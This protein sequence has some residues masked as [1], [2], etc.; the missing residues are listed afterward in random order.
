MNLK[1]IRVGGCEL[2]TFE[3]R[4]NQW[5][6]GPQVAQM[7][8]IDASSLKK[9]AA[10]NEIKT[11]IATEEEVTYLLN[12]LPNGQNTSA[13]NLLSFNETFR[14][15]ES[16][17][18]YTKSDRKKKEEEFECIYRNCR[19]ISTTKLAFYRH[20]LKHDK[21]FT[22]QTS[23][24]IKKKTQRS[25][26]TEDT[27]ITLE[28][29]TQ[30]LGKFMNSTPISLRRR[31]PSVSSPKRE[32]SPLPKGSE[33]PTYECTFD[34]KTSTTEYR[35][36]EKKKNE[37]DDDDDDEMFVEVPDTSV[38]P[39]DVMETDSEKTNI[40]K[41]PKVPPS[42]PPS[43]H[44]GFH[45]DDD[46]LEFKKDYSSFEGAPK[47]KVD[48]E[49]KQH[50]DH[51]HEHEHEHEHVHEQER[52]KDEK[53]KEKEEV[54]V[55]QE[56]KEEEKEETEEKEEDEENEEKEE[57]EENEESEEKE[58]I[59]EEDNVEEKEKEE[60]TNKRELRNRKNTKVWKEEELSEEEHQDMEGVEM[61]SEDSDK[62]E[63]EEEEWMI[64][65]R[66]DKKVAG[67]KSRVKNDNFNN[68]RVKRKITPKEEK[69]KSKSP[70]RGNCVVISE[71]EYEYIAKNLLKIRER[72][73]KHNKKLH[74]NRQK[75]KSI[76]DQSKTIIQ[77]EHELKLELTQLLKVLQRKER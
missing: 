22:R 64:N 7:L 49:R 40:R 8:D 61:E 68:S 23:T 13:V 63:Q 59:E 30:S 74:S 16:N 11:A 2:H 60:E 56:E 20:S 46:F 32:P 43:P 55:E 50:K 76:V 77:K 29:S 71:Q 41:A 21:K 26:S 58:D 17:N 65:K 4:G 28:S 24:P 19:K 14:Y 39:E 27:P 62:E 70:Q 72:E 37:D 52:D 3:S 48:E 33:S 57:L 75:L 73:A 15:L 44:F 35:H 69:R 36:F 54:V 18:C 51:E 25:S 5:L 53:E 31:K 1:P 12:I 10:M 47:E 9:V 42:T 38:E 45:S 66:N 34:A 67:G 6:I